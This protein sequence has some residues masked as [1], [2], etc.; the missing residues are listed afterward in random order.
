MNNLYVSVEEFSELWFTR[1]FVGS[2]PE[3]LVFRLFDVVLVDGFLATLKMALAV[4]AA[5]LP[6]LM[7][8]RDSDDFLNRLKRF[9]G[10]LRHDDARA[11][12]D[13]VYTSDLTADKLQAA[14]ERVA[15]AR[16]VSTTTH[17]ASIF[18][19]ALLP[20]GSTIITEEELQVV[21]CVGRVHV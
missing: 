13:G 6:M 20:D 10:N 18:F 3:R 2:V 7:A 14:R 1:G 21:W 4:M 12:L 8:C 15:A 9:A 17:G 19:R 11:V 5:A 16:T